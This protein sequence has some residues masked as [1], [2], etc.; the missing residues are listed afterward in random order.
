MRKSSFLRE[1]YLAPALGEFRA[2]LERL[3]A[4]AE[5]QG[6]RLVLLTQPVLWGAN[7]APELDARCWYGWVGRP[8]WEGPEAYVSLA[9]MAEGMERYNA[10][11]RAV[12]ADRGLGLVDLAAELSGDPEVF[13]DDCHFTER[14]AQRVAELVAMAIGV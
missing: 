11:L 7:L 4:I 9:A 6:V 2:N 3:A 8:P 14:G 10:V 13:Y 1:R 5:E 12:A